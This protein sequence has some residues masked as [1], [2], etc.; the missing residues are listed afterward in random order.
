MPK[1]V[2]VLSYKWQKLSLADLSRKEIYEKDGGGSSRN[3]QEGWRTVLRGETFGGSIHNRIAEVVW[4]WK[5]PLGPWGLWWL[6]HPAPR[7]QPC[8]PRTRPCSSQRRPRAHS[9]GPLLPYIAGKWQSRAP[10]SPFHQVIFSHLLHLSLLQCLSEASSTV[11]MGATTQDFTTQDILY[12]DICINIWVNEHKTGSS[13]R[14]ETITIDKEEKDNVKILC[15]LKT[16]EGYVQTL[17]K[18]ACW[19]IIIHLLLNISPQWTL[20]YLGFFMPYIKQFFTDFVQLLRIMHNEGF[21]HEP[22]TLLNQQVVL[23]VLG[24]WALWGSHGQ[25]N[26]VSGPI[27]ISP[28]GLAEMP[29]QMNPWQD[30]AQSQHSMERQALFRLLSPKL[31]FPSPVSNRDAV[32]ACQTPKLESWAWATVVQWI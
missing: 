18:K 14:L 4:W 17:F 24:L 28:T 12:S 27:H 5:W 32:R 8:R 11:H 20:I 13:V 10:G 25:G 26:T 3:C 1:S 9:P 19:Q 23:W 21:T 22:L 6:P 2:Q 29:G 30:P 16:L 31:P 7:W 15:N